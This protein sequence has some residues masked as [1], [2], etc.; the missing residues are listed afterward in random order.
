MSLTSSSKS[1]SCVK[2]WRAKRAR[3][4][5]ALPASPPTTACV[6]S[7]SVRPTNTDPSPRSRPVWVPHSDC[8]ECGAKNSLVYDAE[9]ASCIECATVLPHTQVF[10]TPDVFSGP[11]AR[12]VRWKTHMYERHVYF[13][14]IINNLRGEGNAKIPVAMKDTIGQTLMAAPPHLITPTIVTFALKR[15][16]ATKY[17]HA[18]VRLAEKYSK[19][20]YKAVR[21]SK[22][23]YNFFFRLFSQVE[24]VYTN[25][26]KRVC[27][28][29]KIFFNY[30]YLFRRLCQMLGCGHYCRDVPRLQSATA[31][32]VQGRLW[33]AVC[34]QLN[35]YWHPVIP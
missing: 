17:N 25:V 34:V 32:S 30:G 22:K 24:R 4:T 35:W 5:L 27:P 13:R 29:R 16:K 3:S 6:S 31:N 12:T 11:S 28:K 26:R 33:R 1:I 7:S 10:R 18:R 2:R 21:I 23:H 14:Q 8:D 20:L 19:G 9:C 15:L